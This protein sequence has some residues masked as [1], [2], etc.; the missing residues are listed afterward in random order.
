[1]SR[2]HV[3]M[4]VTDENLVLWNPVITVSVDAED[5]QEAQDFVMDLF[6]DLE[7]DVTEIDVDEEQSC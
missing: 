3:H 5:D 1:M 7:F 2:H 4:T 6:P